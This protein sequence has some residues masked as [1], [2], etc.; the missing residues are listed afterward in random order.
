MTLNA[1]QQLHGFDLT[2]DDRD[3]SVL[4]HG[5][6]G[7]YMHS[8]DHVKSMFEEWRENCR[9]YDADPAGYSKR[10]VAKARMI[11]ERGRN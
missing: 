2:I 4:R 8:A 7:R 3:A 9:K 10:A 6:P 11:V 1:L 5:G